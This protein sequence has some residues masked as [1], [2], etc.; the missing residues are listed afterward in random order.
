MFYCIV[1]IDISIQNS[2]HQIFGLFFFFTIDLHYFP[3]N[4]VLFL[5]MNSKQILASTLLVNQLVKVYTSSYKIELVM[6]IILT[7]LAESFVR[8][9]F[10]CRKTSQSDFTHVILVPCLDTFSWCTRVSHC[11]CRRRSCS[12]LWYAGPAHTQH[13][14]K[15]GGWWWKWLWGWGELLF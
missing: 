5:G 15:W 13:R 12:P 11:P 2:G 10:N 14:R 3:I 8:K 7:L 1:Y 9:N 6:H 4:T